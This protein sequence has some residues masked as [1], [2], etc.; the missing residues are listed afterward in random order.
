MADTYV[1]SPASSPLSGEVTVPGDKS[2]SHRAVMLGAIAEGDT[3]VRG[4]L[5]GADNIATINAFR[6]M[7]VE[8]DDQGGGVLLVKGRGR[9]GL[10][11]P[12][13]V[14]DAGN[15]GTTAR[16]LTGL[17][18]GQGFFVVLTGDESLRARPMGRVVRPLREMGAEISG[19]KGATLL[20]LALG[21]AELC[22]IKYETPV[23]SAQ[24]KSAILLAGLFAKGETAVTEPA[25]SRD[26]TERMLRAMGACVSSAGT[27]VSVE[28]GSALQ[29]LEIEVPG[30]ISSA[31]F[32]MAAA[33]IVPGSEIL[34][35][36][37]GINPTRTG[38][39]DILKAMGGDICILKRRG[40]GIEPMADILVK[41]S[42]LRGVEIDGAA[43]LPAIDEF[44]IICVAAAY[45]E[46]ATKISGA[47]E[48]RVKESDR[49][50]AMAGVLSGMGVKCVERPDGIEI[51]GSRFGALKGG[52]FETH[53]DH[54]VA[55]SLAVAALGAG[56]E[57]RIKESE[58][59]DVSYPGFFSDLERVREEGAFRGS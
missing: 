12:G 46:G 1:I 4:F 3:V 6:A 42:P 18:A 48:L 44:P 40:E 26:H 16:L 54:R 35:R 45:A 36:N 22:G 15:S 8:I 39:I 57:V 32:F 41:A 27:T 17:L 38:V 20:P 37:V 5:R 33:L 49:V 56:G 43:L 55:M 51:E 50:A 19:R 47:S 30:D 23:A 28:G 21:P 31:A 58:C 24:L 34:I 14:I 11:E 9:S 29:G 7:G 25:P 52:E 59:V 53:G 2:I 13:D 10:S